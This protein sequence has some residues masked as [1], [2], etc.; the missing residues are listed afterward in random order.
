MFCPDRDQALNPL[1]RGP[2][3]A[4]KVQTFELK[5]CEPKRSSERDAWVL[6]AGNIRREPLI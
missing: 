5:S 1:I 3:L 4:L 2:V 6:R